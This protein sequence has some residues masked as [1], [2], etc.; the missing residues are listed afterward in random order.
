MSGVSENTPPTT[1]LYHLSGTMSTRHRKQRTAKTWRESQVHYLF[2]CLALSYSSPHNVPNLAIRNP[3]TPPPSANQF[4]HRQRP[5]TLNST[6]ITY[7]FPKL[8]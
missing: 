7:T 2:P 4:D 3:T 1:L 5:N 8:G 6:Q